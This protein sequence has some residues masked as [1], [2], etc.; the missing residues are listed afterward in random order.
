MRFHVRRATLNLAAASVGVLCVAGILAGC[1]PGRSA[2]I[3]PTASK[4]PSASALET[5]PTPRPVAA[6]TTERAALAAANEAVNDDEL[7][8]FLVY[9]NK[10]PGDLYG[11]FESGAYRST[12]F[13]NANDDFE[14]GIQVGS[15]DYGYSGMTGQVPLWFPNDAKSSTST[16]VVKGKS[17]PHAIADLTGCI[18]DRRVFV[19]AYSVP[20]GAAT[21]TPFPTPISGSV[22]DPN[23]LTPARITVEYQPSK[24]VWLITK[25]LTLPTKLAASLCHPAHR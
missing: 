17:Y 1:A 16:L 18:Q 24:R 25:E 4:A 22:A 19:F 9:Q 3:A 20:E 6:P 10:I 15:R 2:P 8:L 12:M 7:T 13:I 5:R 14:S 11:T 21:P 23:Q